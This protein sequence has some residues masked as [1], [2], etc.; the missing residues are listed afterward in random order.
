MLYSKLTL[1]DTELVLPIVLDYLNG[2][3]F[4]KPFYHKSNQLKEYFELINNKNFDDNNRVTLHKVL[5][6][7]YKSINLSEDQNPALFENIEKLKLNNTFTIT[8]GHQL[9]LFGGPLFVTYKI[10]TAVKLCFELQNEYPQYNFVPLLWLAS[11]DHDFEE[12]SNTHLYGKDFKWYKDTHNKSVGS[13]DLE[14]LK[15][16]ITNI[17]KLIGNNETG[18]KWIQLINEAYVNHQNL[19]NAS[20]HFYTQLFKELGLI[21]L[22]P[23]KKE[24]KESLISIMKSDILEQV[25]Y[26]AQ[27]ETDKLLSEKYKLQINAREINFFYQH[28]TEGRKLIKYEGD[29]FSVSGTTLS[30]NASEIETEILNCPEKFSPNVNL[31]PVYQEIILPN[32]AYIGGPAEVAYWLQ[33][34]SIFDAHSINYPAVVLRSMNLLIGNQLLEK[35]E[36]FGLQISDLIGSELKMTQA[37][38]KKSSQ[39]EFQL[40]Y[41]LILNEFQKLIDAS[42][43]LDKD[44]SKSLLETKLSIKDFFH[45]KNK[46]LKKSI[47]NSEAT[48]IEKLIKIRSKIYPKNTFQERMDTLLQHEVNGNRSLIEEIL[49]QIS[50][51]EPQ[52]N[53]L[54]V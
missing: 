25:S 33:L 1:A 51:F 41:D 17:S 52:M 29:N 18:L 14:G 34:K 40:S 49:E 5:T 38:L 2:T 12:I 13:I 23:D 28:E 32:L 48:Q 7:Q 50:I 21:V 37:Y 24:L 42:K 6:E 53:I 43:N 8:T 16:D 54:I 3:D 31:R 47:E 4:L 10:L 20:V 26:K 19:A 39:F 36:K 11:E 15:E 46:D 27:I 45:Q 35:V 44:Y 22:N 9:C 30:F